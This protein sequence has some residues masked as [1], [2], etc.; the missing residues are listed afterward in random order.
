VEER[1]FLDD[2]YL[3][4][5]LFVEDSLIEEYVRGGLSLSQRSSFEGG[6]LASDRRRQKWE[7]SRSIA[8]FFS[9]RAATR[10]F[11]SSFRRFL[12][13]LSRGMRVSLTAC[14]L[15]SA[16][17]LATIGV[18]DLSL[19]R[20][21]AN[22]RSH[23]AS[24]ESGAAILPAT[25][26]FQITSGRLRSGP[27]QILPI[28]PGTEWVTLQAQLS[29]DDLKYSSFEAELSKPEGTVIWKQ[30]ELAS[31]G[32]VVEIHLPAETLKAGDYIVSIAGVGPQGRV[33]FPSYQFRV[34]R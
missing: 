29:M 11:F 25:A 21:L 7:A 17:I 34:E 31:S 28:P 4:F 6:F 1:Y 14:A 30:A 24:L 32:Q 10:G 5:L 18:N 12:A 23:L 19:Q 13:G 2:A 3:E 27:G 20:Q 22:T 9:E 15:A 26:L 33:E 8:S 16:G